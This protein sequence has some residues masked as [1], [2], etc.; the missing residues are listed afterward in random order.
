MSISFWTA[1]NRN[2][3]MYIGT[4]IRHHVLAIASSW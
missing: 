4:D 1:M 2:D 3:E